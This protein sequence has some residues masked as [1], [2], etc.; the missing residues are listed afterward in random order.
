MMGQPNRAHF[1]LGTKEHIFMGTCRSLLPELSRKCEVIR[2][3]FSVAYYSVRK[4]VSNCLKSVSDLSYISLYV[5]FILCLGT[6][7]N[8]LVSTRHLRHC[9][10]RYQCQTGPIFE[11]YCNYF[12]SLFCEYY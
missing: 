1:V 9:D 7:I 2:D 6:G 5:I 12:A 11:Y 4:S 3:C 8:P 10:L